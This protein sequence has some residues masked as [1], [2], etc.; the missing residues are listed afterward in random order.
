LKTKTAT[1]LHREGKKLCIEC[2]AGRVVINSSSTRR[3]LV[4][5]LA[6]CLLSSVLS[7]S[8]IYKN[9]WRTEN[10]TRIIAIAGSRILEGFW[11]CRF[12]SH[13]FLSFFGDLDL[14]SC[15]RKARSRP[16]ARK[17]YEISLGSTPE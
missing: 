5:R 12:L 10:R 13:F 16:V 7:C 4:V 2:C 11:C 1:A 15:V 6:W 9:R 14:G 8:F 3:Q 17:V